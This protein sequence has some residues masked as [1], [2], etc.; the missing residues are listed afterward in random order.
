MFQIIKHWFKQYFSDPEA[1]LLFFVLLLSVL[2]VVFF[3]QL[4]A[5]V[6]A[7]IVIA[8]ILEWVITCL[9]GWKLPRLLAVYLVFIG[10]LAFLLVALLV[11][12]PLV[13]QQVVTLFDD[14]PTMLSKGQQV[15]LDFVNRFPEL[16][17]QVQVQSFANELLTQV[18]EGAKVVLSASWSSIAGLMTF[19]VYLILV[20]LLVF[21][22]LKDKVTIIQWG[23]RF[24]P[25]KRGM[26]RRVSAEV[27]HQIANY[28]RGKVL[29]IVLVGLCTYWLFWY[30]GLRYAV[31]LACLVGLSSLIPYVGAM[32]ISI[33][34]VLVG[35]LQWG[36]QPHFGYFMLAYL[37]VLGL[38]GNILV[39]LLF[40]EAVNLH[41][42]AI[43]VA[44]LFFGGV[45]GFWGI[46]F[47]IPLATVIKA[48]L[49]VWPKPPRAVH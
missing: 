20:P 9:E 41:P 26:L 46:F 24:L 13:C 16:F 2:L 32:V 49:N 45:W 1:V 42:I 38:D 34:V 17:S 29:E 5:P 21:F 48:V 10:F 40:S 27:N 14:L 39:P 25:R 36:W 23:L 33:P 12:L 37:T 18:H 19:M 15:L 3:G 30:F 35:Y 11:L 7:S 6:L 43:I 47:A 4:L 22:L 28:I 31:L 44:T 8:Y